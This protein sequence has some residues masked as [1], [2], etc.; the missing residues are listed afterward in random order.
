MLAPAV[1]SDVDLDVTHLDVVPALPNYYAEKH[2]VEVEVMRAAVRAQEDGYD[3]L[4]IGCCYDPGLVQ[5]RELVDIPVIG[6]LEASVGM[7]HA[8]GHR[9]AVVTDMHKAVPEISDR[10]RLYG[11]EA[12]CVGVTSVG[13]FIDAIVADPVGLAN[14]AYAK[15][16]AVMGATGAETV[17]L[18]CTIVSAFYEKAA[19]SDPR[20]RALSVMNPNILALKQA[21][22]LGDLHRLGQYR[23]SRAS[24][25]QRVDDHSPDDAIVLR[26]AL[27]P[28]VPS[29]APA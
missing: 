17:I 22:A 12:N 16:H 10:I 9:Y 3:A 6:P 14:D 20:L 26:R 24:Y 21:E 25:Y 13:W 27:F 11:Q 5:A 19:L 29:S 1:R 28:D 15:V 4:V 7:A 8:F 2:L 23:I 18:G